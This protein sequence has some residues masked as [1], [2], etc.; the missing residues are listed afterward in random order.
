M[1]IEISERDHLYSLAMT[2]NMHKLIFQFGLQSLELTLRHAALMKP[3]PFD[4]INDNMDSDS[5]THPSMPPLMTCSSASSGYSQPIP[6]P[7][8]P[9][10]PLSES[11]LLKTPMRSP[12]PCPTEDECFVHPERFI[13]ESGAWWDWYQE[14]NECRRALRRL[15]EAKMMEEAFGKLE[16]EEEL[17]EGEIRE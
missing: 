11:P 13:Y 1:P 16:H 12:P 2:A 15:E 17:E 5:G 8:I 7:P 10:C 14:Q 6:S 9:D 3:G 4:I